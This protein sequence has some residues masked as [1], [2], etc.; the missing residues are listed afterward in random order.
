MSKLIATLFGLGQFPVAPGTVGSAAAVITAVVASYS[1][2]GLKHVAP[3]VVLMCIFGWM[4]VSAA[5]QEFESSDP[6]A[7]IIDEFVGQWIALL[8]LYHYAARHGDDDNTLC[9]PGVALAFILFRVLDIY[10]P[11]LIGKADALPG[12]T[13]II[14]DDILAGVATAIVVIALAEIFLRTS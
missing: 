5:L 8:P 10:K 13:G 7:I 14:F 2:V 4:A 3:A 11:S 6:S 9:F 12:A 1:G